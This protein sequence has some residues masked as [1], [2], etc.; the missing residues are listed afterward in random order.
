MPLASSFHRSAPQS[1]RADFVSRRL[2]L[3]LAVPLLSA[4]F[5]DLPTRKVVGSFSLVALLRTLREE[6][7]CHERS[8]AGS[9]G[10]QAGRE[11]RLDEELAP[12]SG[13]ALRR[14]AGRRCSRTR[15]ECERGCP[16]AAGFSSRM[17]RC[18]GHERPTSV[19]RKKPLFFPHQHLSGARH[20]EIRFAATTG[21]DGRRLFAT[22]RCS[23]F[24]FRWS[25]RLDAV[26]LLPLLHAMAALFHFHG[27]C[28][29]VMM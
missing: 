5:Q 16:S 10:G 22:K 18:H 8:A 20:G 26:T 1:G 2:H 27:A 28:G 13:N 29:A 15:H 4:H 17:T 7:L 12:G 23:T 9:G 14:S 21:G 6:R 3:I 11:V 24:G 25:A 19:G